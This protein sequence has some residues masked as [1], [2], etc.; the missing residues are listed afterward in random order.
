VPFSPLAYLT[1]CFWEVVGELEKLHNYLLRA[2]AVLCTE[3]AD[4]LVRKG[5]G[6]G[7]GD[8]RIWRIVGLREWFHLMPLP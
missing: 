3:M 7:W 2:V 6:E 4:M 8:F 1:H 5:R